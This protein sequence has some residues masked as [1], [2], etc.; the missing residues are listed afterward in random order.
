MAKKGFT[1]PQMFGQ[2]TDLV[3]QGFSSPED[4]LSIGSTGQPDTGNPYNEVFMG[5]QDLLQKGQEDIYSQVLEA[6]GSHMLASQAASGSASDALVQAM[7]T[8]TTPSDSQI[9]LDQAVN[10]VIPMYGKDK[11]YEQTVDKFA[12]AY[13]VNP[14]T[15]NR[16]VERV[17]RQEEINS[18]NWWEGEEGVQ[19]PLMEMVQPTVVE[20]IDPARTAKVVST[21][22]E[23]EINIMQRVMQEVTDTVVANSTTTR[24]SQ[25]QTDY[26]KRD[27]FLAANP[28]VAIQ[29]KTAGFPL[30]SWQQIEEWFSGMGKYFI[31]AEV[32]A[33]APV[34][35]T[36]YPDK[37]DQ[38][39]DEVLETINVDST[40]IVPDKDVSSTIQPIP[41]TPESTGTPIE[42]TEEIYTALLQ[43]MGT[44]VM[45]FAGSPMGD[46]G[47]RLWFDRSTNQM[48][49]QS[50]ENYSDLF[51][52]GEMNLISNPENPIQRWQ[53]K[54]TEEMWNYNPNLSHYQPWSRE[55][56]KST[57]TSY[58]GAYTGPYNMGMEP[59]ALT[60]KPWEEQWDAIRYRQMG[61]DALNPVLWGPRRQGLRQATG[62]Y[63]MSGSPSTFHEWLPNRPD[64]D[65]NELWERLVDTSRFAM[66][67][68]AQQ[69]SEEDSIKRQQLS[70]F[71][72]GS[73]ARTAILNM[74]AT[75]MGA[76]E[77]IGSE[78]LR[79]YLGNMYDL[80]AAQQ[81]A[82]GKPVAGF[83]AWIEDQRTKDTSI[84]PANVLSL[85]EEGYQGVE[86]TFP[87][88]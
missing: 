79:R 73:G 52:L 33:Q 3:T 25:S 63:M 34:F 14:G 9:K 21:L 1:L 58:T 22:S 29:F 82:A 4:I 39:I 66:G 62:Q 74:T 75:A 31:P 45:E 41:E 46:T 76:Q 61:A 27:D 54:N 55:Q 50:G 24:M 43:K 56:D 49:K 36:L 48:Y 37:V 11:L 51:F 40:S 71:M 20:Q 16:E 53:N 35:N 78:G 13:G 77:G 72:Q 70:G 38:E 32:Q 30:P 69:L 87:Y 86:E 28:D 26:Q 17:K 5:N 2:L 65:K 60:G 88:E 44:G 81:G 23:E 12:N 83:P 10:D 64:L 6:T 57:S 84:A 68:K 42:K 8:D 47:T 15:L 7:L 18:R 80:Y 85:S 59:S 67:E 19:L